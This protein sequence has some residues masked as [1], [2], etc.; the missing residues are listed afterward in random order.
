MPEKCFTGPW[1]PGHTSNEVKICAA[2]DADLGVIRQW[3]LDGRAHVRCTSSDAMVDELI[4]S[5]RLPRADPNGC[6]EAEPCG[7]ALMFAFATPETVFVI[8]AGEIPALHPHH[9]PLAHALC[10]LFA[11]FTS[12]WALGGGGEEEVGEAFTRTVIHPCIIGQLPRDEI[13][14]IHVV[15]PTEFSAGRCGSSHRW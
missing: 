3:R 13:H 10:C 4:C 1:S 5:A 11:Q 12:L 7:V 8:V 9:A 14:Q 15:P 6:D 2:N